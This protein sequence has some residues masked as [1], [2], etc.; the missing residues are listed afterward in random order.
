PGD[1]H[2]YRVER[3]TPSALALRPPDFLKDFASVFLLNVPSLPDAEWNRLSLYVH[4]GGGLVVA[5]GNR[6]DRANY[7]SA[8]A[9]KLLPAVP[10]QEKPKWG[11]IAFVVADAAHP[12]LS[13]FPKEIAENLASVLVY[14]HAV[15]TPATGTRTILEYQ[16][17]APAL[18]ERAFAGP[19]TGRVLLWTTP[20]SR[21]PVLNA[22]EDPEAWNEFPADGERF[23]SFIE[24]MDRT[25]PYLA[26]VA[27]RQLNYEAGSHVS[28]P[29]DPNNRFTTFTVQGPDPKQTD[30]L[31][32]PGTK[33][34]LEIEPPA[35]L[36][37]WTVTASRPDG[38]SKVYGFSVNAPQAELLLS[39]L[40]PRELEALFGGKDRYQLADTP[41]ALKQ[42]VQ[43]ARVGHEVFPWM[44]LL[45]L[46]LVTAENYLANRFYRERPA[47]SGQAV[48]A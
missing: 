35:Q 6:I 25:V 9:A 18:L 36:G 37:Q 38:L 13:R 47:A 40:E 2:P 27:D 30:R 3:I 17:K 22:L 10:A 28:L 12:I 41:E 31:T 46:A 14:R 4:Q 21:K 23:W 48:V 42:V 29:L 34:T 26:G 7:N 20:L 45:I 44:M 43:T 16:N 5:L 32:E 19:K 39:P 15:V 24:I 11:E 1:P 8:I 33:E